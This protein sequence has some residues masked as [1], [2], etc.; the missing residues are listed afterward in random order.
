MMKAKSG[1]RNLFML[2]ALTLCATCL[3]GSLA[4]AQSANR[5]MGT[6]T[7]ID[8]N[9]LTIKTAQGEEHTVQIPASAEIKQ[10]EPGQTN[11]NAAVAMQMSELA[12]GDRVLVWIDP[13]ATGTTPSALRLVAIKASDLARK[14]QQE[15]EAWQLH[16][17]G[18]LVKSL[19]SA[20]GT[21]VITAG[22]G[23]QAHAVTVHTTSSTILKRYAPASVRF[24]S[25]QP[26]PFSAIHVGDQLM[27]RGVKNSAGS[28][29]QADQ[30]VSG[31][32]RNVS[33]LIAS[34]DAANS[35]FTIKD[36]ASK[37]TITAKVPAEAQ[38]RQLPE[39]M[40]QLLA[41][42]LKGGAP[43]SD[44]G[45]APPGN[46]AAPGQRG[47][48]MQRGGGGGAAAD[49]QQMLNR[50]PAIH[51][52]DLKKGDAVMLVATPGD[53]EVTVIT[54][55]AGVEPLLQAPESQDLLSNW[56]MNSSAPEADTGVQ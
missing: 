22:G 44:G 14:R 7:S 1:N 34:L 52:S 27:A 16:G 26:A 53:S 24:D 28:E 42:R 15:A 29:V 45:A 8:G 18:G 41:T 25:A 17:A 10:I 3:A 37:K 50:A 23:S 47:G 46:S 43:A 32:F 20:T 49:P 2:L 5:Y 39:R 56:S 21:I 31:S 55:I 40:A 54:L 48:F 33:G 13:N 36:L 12:S 51:F 11:L 9:T 19:D 38:M 30:V 4:F 35:T 6:V